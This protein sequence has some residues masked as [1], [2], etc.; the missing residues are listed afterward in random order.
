MLIQCD[1]GNC[2]PKHVLAFKRFLLTVK[3][4]WLAH[5]KK[6]PKGKTV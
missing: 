3:L 2:T 1:K 4:Y 5:E 6:F